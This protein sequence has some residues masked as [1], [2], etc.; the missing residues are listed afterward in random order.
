MDQNK[1]SPRAH[2]TPTVPAAKRAAVV[3]GG[4]SG[5][6]AAMDLQAAGWQVGVYDAAASWGGCVGV[7]E[8]A[9]VVLDSGAE[10]FATR[11]T[12]VADLAAELGLGERIV[13]PDPAGAW[14][15]LPEGPVPLPRTGILGIPSDLH[16]PEVREALGASGVLRAALDAKMPVSVGTTEAQC[17][18]AELVRARM[19]R[20]VLER[21]VAPVVAGVHS[22]DPEVLD[23]DMVAPGLRAGIR[24]HGS[25]AAAVAAQRSAKGQS[26]SKPGSAVGGLSG[27]MHTLAAALVARLRETGAAL[28][29]GHA[30]TAIHRTPVAARGGGRDD[31]GAPSRWTVDWVA[32]ADSGSESVDLLVVATDGPTA[33]KLLTPELPELL[34]FAPAPGPDIRLVTLVVD[35][36]ELDSKP[37]G[38]GVLVAPQVEGITAKALTHATA[39]WEWLADSTGPGTH[40]LRLSY[41]RAGV[42]AADAVRLTPRPVKDEDLVATALAD[43]TKLLGV[44]VTEADVLGA[45]IVRWKGALPFAAVGH[46][47]KMAHIHALAQKHHGLVLTG[48]WMSGNGLAAVVAG[49]RRQLRAVVDAAADGLPQR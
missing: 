34:P 48:G 49:T 32:G 17:S 11:S 47:A 33:V 39:K 2:R 1:H 6:L 38:T 5:L 12:A 8:V 28:H 15:W 30:V 29:A 44:A 13:A 26:G 4:I 18:L 43:A 41:G 31:A 24:E 40:V 22:A 3:G 35:V 14:V 10:S 7:H 23:V 45:D 42:A 36:P 16:A 19:G 25:L 46:Q 20:R 27:G 21:L 37:R 9:G